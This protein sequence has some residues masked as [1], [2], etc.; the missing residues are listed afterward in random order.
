MR[1]PP[2]GLGLDTPANLALLSAERRRRYLPTALLAVLSGVL[3]ALTLAALDHLLFAGASVQRVRALGQLSWFQRAEIVVF[4]ATTEEIAYRLVLA[5]AMG[6]LIF[7]ALR[8]TK[9]ESLALRG[10]PFNS[11]VASIHAALGDKTAA[12]G[13]LELAQSEHESGLVWIKIDPRFDSLR[14]EP[15]FVEILRKMG[16]EKKAEP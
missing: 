9:L 13:W 3:T 7:L 6:A 14:A 8:K 1:W 11:Q 4:S 2:F 12:L 16:L 5:T 10:L 15:R